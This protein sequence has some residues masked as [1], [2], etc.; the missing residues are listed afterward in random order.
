[1][2]QEEESSNPFHPAAIFEPK[3]GPILLMKAFFFAADTI[4]SMRIAKKNW[5]GI[6]LSQREGSDKKIYYT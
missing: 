6:C 3:S 2:Q 4:P 5:L 1:V